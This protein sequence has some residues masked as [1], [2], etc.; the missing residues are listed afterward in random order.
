MSKPLVVSIPHNLGKAEA[1]R[2]LHGGM[3]GLK[4]QFGDK[5]ASIDESWTGDR[6]D[7]RVGAMGQNVSGNVLV[8]DEQVRVEVQLPWLLAM[9]AEKAKSFI[10]KQGTLMLEKK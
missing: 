10:Q 4:S 9:I 7:F 5:V 2:R 8:M 3:S 1:L 6:M